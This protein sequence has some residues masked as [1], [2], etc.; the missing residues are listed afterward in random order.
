[1]F[2]RLPLAGAVP[3]PIAAVEPTSENDV[4]AIPVVCGDDAG[5]LPETT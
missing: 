2:E 1:M 3:P 5:F 4:P